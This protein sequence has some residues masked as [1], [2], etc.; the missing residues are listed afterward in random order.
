VVP[1]E[2]FSEGERAFKTIKDTLLASYYSSGVTEDDLYRAAAE[3]MLS[4][5]D[6]KM[7][8]WNK[9]LSPSDL[10]A[11]EAD[12]KGEVV[13]VGVK[14]HFD[15]ASGYSDVLGVVPGSP[16]ERAQIQAG[17]KILSV[18]GKLYKGKASNAIINDIR[19]K[20]GEKVA[21]SILREDKI[22][23]VP[24]VR[25]VV[26]FDAASSS[27]LP[28]NVGYVRIRAF[29]EKTPP[30]LK[31]ALSKVASARAMVVDLRSN[32]GG[33]FDAAVTCAGFFFKPGAAI[34]RLEKRGG[35]VETFSA[36]GEQ[37][38]GDMPL[39]VLVDGMTSSGAEFVAASLSEVRSAQIVGTNTYGKWSV[40]KLDKLQN[41]YA[42][43]FTTSLFHTPSG[44]TYN[45][46]G[47]AP[48]VA[49]SMED[50]AFEAAQA[51]ADPDKRLA[52]DVQL[53]T[54]VGLVRAHP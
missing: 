41:G 10:A 37:I 1:A 2:K 25:E 50:K 36:K 34:V 54:A 7:H 47:L 6:P 13:G 39:A 17:D 32:A 31:Q 30:T 35:A 15:S 27:M 51:I 11:I 4:R 29:T 40:Q 8:K 46:V 19:G 20:A 49:V 16:A 53:R 12:L 23:T 38:V 22:L 42:M 44:K 45:G 48:D 24:L 14:I 43:K 26:A 21:L 3:G 18:D 33:M 5:L 52:A 28:G 9:L